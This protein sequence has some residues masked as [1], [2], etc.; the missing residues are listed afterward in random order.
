MSFALHLTKKPDLNYA[1][2]LA[3]LKD[4][5]RIVVA[6]YGLGKY[7]A[8]NPL[9]RAL[10]QLPRGRHVTVFTAIPNHG[11]A[12]A[13]DSDEPEA[14]EI[15][16]ILTALDPS[17]FECDVSAWFCPDNHAKI[18]LGDDFAYV[19]S[20]LTQGSRFNFEAGVTFGGSRHLDEIAA[21][22]DEMQKRSIPYLD[23]QRSKLLLR[24]FWF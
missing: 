24:L 19:G 23:L 16:S 2:I 13:A 11:A 18:V 7:P 6:T 1:A 12:G 3:R 17:T 8:N 15:T 14:G 10:H 22:F 20:N 21:F 4:T 9:L 5:K